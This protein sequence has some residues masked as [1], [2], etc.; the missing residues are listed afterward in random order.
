MPYTLLAWADHYTSPKSHD[1]FVKLYKLYRS[2][3]VLKS[4]III[5]YSYER[6]KKRFIY[7]IYF[8]KLQEHS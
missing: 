7:D 5:P 6:L 1:V 3:V 2:N 4:E 8:N